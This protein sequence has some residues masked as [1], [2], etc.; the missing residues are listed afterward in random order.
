MDSDLGR[1]L[2]EIRLWRQLSLR[3]AAE[4]SGI[5]HGYLG[6]IE[7]GEK[8]VNNRQV[9]EAL[10]L[11]LHVSPSDL[12]GRPWLTADPLTADAQA[13]LLPVE[14]V[15]TEWRPG[16][17]PDD[18]PPRPWNEV[19]HE[20]EKLTNHLR[21][22]SDY[23]AQGAVLPN[24]IHDL[25]CHADAAGEH[26]QRALR[27]LVAAYHAAGNLAARIGTRHLGYVASDRLTQAAELLGEP[28]WLGV[29][30][31][32]RA[33][34]VSSISR[35]RQ[36]TLAVQAVDLPGARLES[37]GM[38][39]LTAALAA[40]AVGNDSM[41]KTH[42]AEASTM[43]DAL[44]LDNSSWGAGTMNFG[45]ANVGIWKVSI[46]VEAGDGG[47][48]AEVAEDV[49]WQAVPASR[50]GAYWMDLG[51]GLLTEKR[52]RDEGLRALLK[53]E[54]LTP[55]QVRNN[56]FVKE[57]V[58]DQLRTA[59]RDAGGRELRGLAWRMGVVPAG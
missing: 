37:R 56:V 7:R 24:L 57:L 54:E 23:A 59:R 27:A 22:T 9:L 34:F 53:A 2:R 43:A 48:V 20:S 30:G 21:P 40:A 55:Q 35:A 1:R 50:Q 47:R 16:E 51:R 25:L 45:R 17:I 41:A 42:L 4:L 10:A 12:T 8:P 46:G 49:P 5:T 28:E 52:T 13:A 26:R 29:A 6:Q 18:A 33:Q 15:L 31:W 11:I 58:A 14:A 19:W 39:H 32:T 38:S 3:A 44:D 36:Y